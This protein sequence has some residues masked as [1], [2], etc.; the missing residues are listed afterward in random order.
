MPAAALGVPYAYDAVR[1][2]GGLV[3]LSSLRA[4]FRHTRATSTT[5]DSRAY[6]ALTVEAGE[7]GEHYFSSLVT[8]SPTG[9]YAVVAASSHVQSLHRGTPTGV[10]SQN[11]RGRPLKS[12]K[13][14]PILMPPFHPARPWAPK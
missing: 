7:V 4:A 5:L 3:N 9:T 11:H 10:P 1:N 2:S 6:A 14:I 8:P 12:L 13:P